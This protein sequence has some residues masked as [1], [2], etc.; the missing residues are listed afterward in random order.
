MPPNSDNKL[1]HFDSIESAL[2]DIAQGKA[3]IVTDDEARENEGDLILAAEKA[4][5]ESINQMILHA[6]GLICVPMQAVQLRRLG[7]NPMSSENRESHRTDFAISVDAAEGITTGISAHDRAK[8]IR[9]LSDPNSPTESLVQPG[10]VFPLRAKPGGVLERAGHTEAAVDLAV[11]AG[12]NPSGVICEI[13]NEDGSL[14]RV[15]DLIEFKKKHGLKLISISQL[16]E[17]RHKKECLIKRISTKKL[18]TEYGEFDFHLFESVL[19]DRQHIALSMGTLDHNPTLVRV[20]SEYRLSD[21]FKQ[22]GTHGSATLEKAL[23]KIA[24]AKQGVLVYIEQKH[25]GLKY[26]KNLLES[27]QIEP[28]KMDPRDYGIGAQILVNLGLK[29]IK[30]L[31]DNPRKVVGLEGYNLSI[32]EQISLSK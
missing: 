12:L 3:V 20:H 1:E 15:P 9:I 25:G 4:T 7:I 24:E 14:A 31:S 2:E 28:P 19:D 17:F 16:I 10:H 23:A 13:L 30:I 5:T 11:L 18:Q 22:K 29:E 32:S 21:I 6:R 27:E 26:L 8:T